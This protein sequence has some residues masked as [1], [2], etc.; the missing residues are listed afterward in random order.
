[1][2]D[3][4]YAQ[5]EMQYNQRRMDTVQRLAQREREVLALEDFQQLQRR[6]L[7]A[8]SQ[9]AQAALSQQESADVLAGALAAIDASQ[10]TLLQKHGYPADYLNEA[11]LC[12][13]THCMDTGYI[14]QLSGL[15]T[16]CKCL[17]RA[18]TDA[19]LARNG[20]SAAVDEHF[21]TYD[22][23]VFPDEGE[24]PTQREQMRRLRDYALDFCQQFPSTNK[25]LLLFSGSAGLGKTFLMNC[26]ARRVTER[27]FTAARVPSYRLVQDALQDKSISA[28]SIQADLLALD[29]L[30]TE[31]LYNNI[32]VETL[33]TILNERM[34][35]G[36][37]T[38]VSTNLSLKQ[39]TDRYTER[40]ASRLFSAKDALVIRLTGR[41]IR[42]K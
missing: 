3:G 31:P 6:R 21:G 32:T 33:Y 41:D 23:N 39:L 25:K 14:T 29:D 12:A 40:I 22:L 11:S 42:R 20:L 30:G 10:R 5:I 27:G 24:A 34:T 8:L 19:R 2:D 38:L 18:L 16:R 7:Q 4:L 1:M 37:Q 17:S 26:I 13:C 15:R 36:K 28:L 35:A 9:A